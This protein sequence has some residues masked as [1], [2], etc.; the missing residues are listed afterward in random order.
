MPGLLLAKASIPGIRF[1]ALFFGIASI[2]VGFHAF[3]DDWHD[4]VAAH[5]WA[6]AM[7]GGAALASVLLLWLIG[8]S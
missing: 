7:V 5:E 1:L 2:V 6:G 3:V 8:A 4:E